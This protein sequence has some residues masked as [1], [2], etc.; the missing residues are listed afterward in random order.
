MSR[1]GVNPTQGYDTL[2]LLCDVL[3]QWCIEQK[4]PY[5]SADELILN[6]ELTSAQ[7]KWLGN[8][9]NLWERTEGAA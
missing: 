4:L 5:E 2:G 3:E 7:R 9:C 8:Y 6:P 1:A